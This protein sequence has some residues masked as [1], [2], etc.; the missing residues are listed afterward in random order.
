MSQEERNVLECR[1]F[2]N[3]GKINPH[4]AQKA[5]QAQIKQAPRLR[6]IVM[7]RRKMNVGK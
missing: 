7:G 5:G 4:Q 2:L 3:E 1:A 6:L